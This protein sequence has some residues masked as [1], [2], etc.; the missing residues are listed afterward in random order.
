[1]GPTPQQLN[2]VADWLERQAVETEL[3]DL[4]QALGRELRQLGEEYPSLARIVAEAQA[5]GQVT[6]EARERFWRVASE[7]VG[8]DLQRRQRISELLYKLVQ[9]NRSREAKQGNGKS[10]K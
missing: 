5:A 3:Y 7:A 1:M 4:R 9:A 6:E 2:S 8:G 10:A